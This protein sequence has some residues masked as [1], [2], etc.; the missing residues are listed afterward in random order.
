[1]CVRIDQAGNNGFPGH[2]DPQSVFG[3]RNITARSDSA[4][5]VAIDNNNAVL[6]NATIS[7]IHGYY[8]CARQRNNA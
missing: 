6:N 4:N 1:M 3:Y 5:A 8:S 2:V 7:R